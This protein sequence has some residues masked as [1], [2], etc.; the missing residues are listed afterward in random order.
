[1]FISAILKMYEEVLPNMDFIHLAQFLTK[2][3]E[4]ISAD[5][6][7]R[8]IDLIRMTIDKKNFSQI[9]ANNKELNDT[10]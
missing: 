4:D 10:T 2:L 9:L 8:C 5:R 7:F 3:P 6:L 1:M